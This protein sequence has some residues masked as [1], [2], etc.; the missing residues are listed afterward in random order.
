MEPLLIW[1]AVNREIE[2]TEDLQK[3]F[4]YLSKWMLP[5]F[6]YTITPH[7]DK[8]ATISTS[9]GQHEKAEIKV[10]LNGI[11]EVIP[12][13]YPIPNGKIVSIILNFGDSKNILI[14]YEYFD[15][16]ADNYS[17]E[18]ESVLSLLDLCSYRIYMEPFGFSAYNGK[19]T[20]LTLYRYLKDFGAENLTVVSYSV[21]TAKS[22]SI[23][24]NK[25]IYQDNILESEYYEITLRITSTNKLSLKAEII[26]EGID[27]QDP[28][29]IEKTITNPF[30]TI[31][32][33]LKK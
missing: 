29:Q 23:S 4:E 2:T 11:I 31:P 30:N 10:K 21:L 15:E 19:V 5:G 33:R 25:L 24:Y 1:C 13:R 9:F 18:L 27:L 7:S 3:L 8:E 6:N 14:P 20:P 12:V 17:D 16:Y 26:I 22:K 32:L 28:I